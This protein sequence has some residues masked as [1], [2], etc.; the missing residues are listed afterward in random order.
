MSSKYFGIAIMYFV[1][2][3][4]VAGC[5]K[6]PGT[7]AASDLEA[8]QRIL[9]RL[10]VTESGGDSLVLEAKGIDIEEGEIDD[11]VECEQEGEHEG[12]N[13][14]C[15]EGDTDEEEV[16]CEDGV[17]P[18]GLPC[19]DE[20]DDGEE[21][22]EDLFEMMAGPIGLSAG[23]GAPLR[24]LGTEMVLPAGT[25]GLDR[26]SYRFSGTYSPVDTFT[27]DAI[28]TTS[29]E[30]YRLL[31]TIDAITVRPDGMLVLHV[32]DKDV[33]VDPDLRV[34]KIGSYKTLIEEDIDGDDVECEQEGEHEGD[35]EGC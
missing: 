2:F 10:A 21:D 30:T 16:E 29:S 26:G 12:E 28:S 7:I 4:V 20:D 1:M 13:E 14:G 5:Q 35:N 3:V 9:V 24:F 17:T 6:V 27:V 19:D 22:G 15:E 34:R 11:S 8:G 33:I 23:E 18:E 25:S 31:T 32:F